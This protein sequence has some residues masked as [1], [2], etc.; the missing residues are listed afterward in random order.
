M[1]VTKYLRILLFT[2]LMFI[3]FAGSAAWAQNRTN[4]ELYLQNGT[5]LKGKVIAED[6]SKT[7]IFEGVDGIERFIR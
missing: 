7:L 3:S 6:P 5:I 4:D 1:K 2:S